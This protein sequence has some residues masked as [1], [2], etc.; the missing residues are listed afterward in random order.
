MLKYK[1]DKAVS[2]LS[3][4]DFEMAL[5]YLRSTDHDLYTMHSLMYHAS[6]ELQASLVCFKDPPVPWG[7]VSMTAVGFL[8]LCYVYAKGEKFFRNKRKQF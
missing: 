2:A 4:L 1:I 3:H 5:Y 8:A 7:S 6:D